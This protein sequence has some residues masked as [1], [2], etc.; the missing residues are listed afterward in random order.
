MQLRRTGHVTRMSEGRIPRQLLYGELEKGKRK[1]GGQ[2]LLFNYVAKRHL[3]SMN[4]DVASWEELAADRN[5]WRCSLS[6]G[7]SAVQSKIIAAS[8][9]KHY[10]RHNPGTVAGLNYDK[11]F[12]IERGLLQHHRMKHGNLS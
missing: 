8:D 6:T 3:K 10:T 11:T 5:F 12:H 2:R 9:L 7:K 4:I 1:P